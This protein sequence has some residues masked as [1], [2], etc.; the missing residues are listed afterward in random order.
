[1][2]NKIFSKLQPTRQAA[3]PSGVVADL[4]AMLSEAVGFKLH[5]KMHVIRPLTVEQFMKLTNK[6]AEI[7][8][9]K[10]KTGI[11]PSEIVDLYY[12]TVSIASKTVTREDIS[13]MNTQQVTAL[14]ELI[15]ETITGKIFTEKKTLM[16]GPTPVPSQ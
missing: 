16:M 14:L 6:M 13:N 8:D 15:I 1:M 11:E 2:F 4:D 9:L 12:S 10:N 7:Y 5:G 3:A